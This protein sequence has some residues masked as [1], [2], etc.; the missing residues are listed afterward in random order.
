MVEPYLQDLENRIDASTE[1]QLLA[2]WTAF[3]Q[4]SWEKGIF[5][6][7]RPRPAPPSLAWPHVMVDDTLDSFQHMALQQLEGCSKALEHGSGAILAVR[8][9]YGT[10]ILPS[11]F[12]AE[13]FIMD[14][15]TDTLPTSWALAGG[16]ETIARLVEAGVPAIAPDALGGRTLAMG[17]YLVDL[18]AEYPLIRRHVHIYHPDLQGPMDICELLWG[19]RLFLDIVDEPGLVR[20]FLALITETYARFLD[21]WH[22]IVPAAPGCAVHWSMQHRG[23]IMLRDDSAMNFSPS[24][25]EEFIEPYDQQLLDRFGGGAIH[26]CGRGE[27]YI[28][29]LP[30]MRGLRAINMSQPEYNDMETIYRH[31]VDRGLQIVGLQRQAAEEALAGGRDLRGNVHCW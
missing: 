24:M 13:L 20:D 30:A 27:H 22:E 23:T 18:F 10:S 29:R 9:N 7:C 11:L 21:A 2:E 19:S 8:A 5:S 4:G 17:R 31:T 1:E 3:S 26:F 15:D 14:R 12:G 25:F 16:T 6:P 28:H